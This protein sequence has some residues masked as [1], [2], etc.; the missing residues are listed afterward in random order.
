MDEMLYH[1]PFVTSTIQKHL[2]EH[3]FYNRKVKDG[4]M[5]VLVVGDGFFAEKFVDL[6]LQ[7]G[8]M[9][10]AK[11]VIYWCVS[12]E[13]IKG[14]YL[15]KRPA[16]AE[17]IEVSGI[18]APHGE[19]YGSLIF[20]DI[21]DCLCEE[22]VECGHVFIATEDEEKNLEYA[23]ILKNAGNVESLAAYLKDGNIE[24]SYDGAP[25]SP[26]F[27]EAK[28]SGEFINSEHEMDRMAFN[29][30]RTWEGEGNIDYDGLKKRFK[31]A[32]YKNASVSFVLS[33]P[34]KLRSIG[35]LEND[36][37]KAA[38]ACYE[39]I[40]EAEEMP[41]SEAS[42]KIA[43]VAALE[44]RR[45]VL[46]KV[47]DGAVPL[48]NMDGEV[49]Y[50]ICVRNCSVK[51]RDE[52]G[53]LIMHPCIVRSTVET[54]LSN[55]RYKDKKN[56]DVPSP[57]DDSLDELDRMSVELHRTMLA[58]AKELKKDKALLNSKLETLKSTC[59]VM[60]G[61][62]KR[63]FDRYNF[64]IENIIDRSLPYTAQFETYERVL[65]KTLTDSHI[66][67]C[68][69]L[70]PVIEDIHKILFPVLESN[71][72]R[73]Y[74]L[75]DTEM[76]KNIPYI[77][78]GKKGNK[79]L[80]SFGKLTGVNCNNN[81]YFYAVASAT[82]L[83]ADAIHYILIYDEKMN[84][85]LLESKLKAIKNYFAYRGRSI[86][87]YFEVFFK[88]DSQD[89]ETELKNLFGGF[90]KEKMLQGY[91]LSAYEQETELI[92]KIPTQLSNINV[93]YFDGS[94]KITESEF[95]N[96][97]VLSKIIEIM[98]YFEFDSANRRFVNCVNC[99]RL[100]YLKITSFIQVEDMFALM[101]AS[102]KE[103]SYQDYADNYLDFWGI[104]SGISLGIADFTLCSRSWTKLCEV[105]KTGGVTTLEIE[106]KA[107]VTE[108]PEEVKT[109]LKMIRGLEAKG[110]VEKVSY[111]TTT[112]KGKTYTTV[113]LK[114]KDV[115]TKRMF[116]KSGDILET[117]VYFEACKTDWFDDVQTG[118]KFKWEFDDVEN[119][120]DCVLTKGFRSILVECKSA[121]DVSED[122][123]L[124]LDSLGDHF[125][126]NYKKVLI[127]VTDVKA[128]S[129]ERYN[130]RGKQMD[131][132]TISSKTD[133]LNIGELLKQIMQDTKG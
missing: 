18:P 122:F 110:Y 89:K 124:I 7:T 80:T 2:F 44:H 95:V 70:L 16:L 64:C 121:K 116:A 73:D 103:F 83:H 100:K 97:Q 17:F 118:Y 69:K 66:P 126:I 130:S 78:T 85:Q 88:K 127:L 53:K 132:I 77:L 15:S 6:A 109:V 98:P 8:Q 25:D 28:E 91:T 65:R 63:D 47:C 60:G 129:Y 14:I 22:C 58:A 1:D 71:L 33:L 27:S 23:D 57:L 117:Y 9:T 24:I 56:W 11:L 106:N 112:V 54:P 82:A 61:A 119:E 114:A 125:G 99:E 4:K 46:E 31:D 79:I 93:D 74:K 40:K 123:Y 94:T 81:N 133:M 29:A 84:T 34:Y 104:Y 76:V 72:Y 120:L 111:G 32:Y 107:I 75:Y 50:S 86:E 10:D 43:L 92:T 131:I 59:T 96:G 39:I 41:A 45:W 37:V 48:V 26:E 20:K 55:G 90:R 128:G 13:S 105:I 3:P 12:D 30:H 35:I 51:Q 108:D 87:V 62:I 19:I 36:P 52:A 38:D 42:K 68:D 102:D 21:A 113:S 67:S 101:N 115:K 5:S 49:D